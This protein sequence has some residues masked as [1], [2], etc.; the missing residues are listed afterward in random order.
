LGRQEQEYFVD[1]LTE[2]VT[3]RL[4]CLHPQHVNLVACELATKYKRTRNEIDRIA[5][6]LQVD[7]ILTGSVRWFVNRVRVTVSLTE[8]SEGIYVWNAV[9]EQETAD[10]LEVQKDIAGKIVQSLALTLA[11]GCVTSAAEM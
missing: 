7:Y 2:E 4:G 6:E 10:L 9:Y 5:Q 8:M 3:A 11:P 1:G